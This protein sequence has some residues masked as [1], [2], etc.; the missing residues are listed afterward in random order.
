M[1]HAALRS[2]LKP[3]AHTTNDDHLLDAAVRGDVEGVRRAFA[4]G[5]DV[6]ATNAAGRCAVSLAI[7][8]EKCALFF[9]SASVGN[10]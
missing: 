10:M 1:E 3:Q 4:L 5:A 6:N 2:P 9:S 8:G 7:A